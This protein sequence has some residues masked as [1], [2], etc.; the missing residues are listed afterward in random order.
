MSR[1]QPE[2]PLKV[3]PGKRLDA[4]VLAAQVFERHGIKLREDDPAFA[5]VTLNELTLRK[6]M[7]ELLQDVDQHITARLAEFE[8]T[9]QRVEAR[10][11]KLLA[12]QVRESAA[13]LRGALREEIASARMGVQQMVEKIQKTH[14]LSTLTRWCA[15]GA[16][17]A[18]VAFACGFWARRLF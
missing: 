9:M 18:V 7:G 12:H 3:V 4:R 11:G 10:A 13:G 1:T 15:V 14:G 5:L 17:V 2:L 6:V 8:L 16:V